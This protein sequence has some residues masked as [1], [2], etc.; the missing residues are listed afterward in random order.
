MIECYDKNVKTPR[1]LSKH[2]TS[3]QK[4][5]SWWN[6][7][8]MEDKMIKYC[9]FTQFWCKGVK[10]GVLLWNVFIFFIFLHSYFI[11]IGINIPQM[12]SNFFFL[13]EI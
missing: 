4:V 13:I 6:K 5:L 3:K 10:L 11:S 1:F 2:V 9:N 7:I 12:K 8:P